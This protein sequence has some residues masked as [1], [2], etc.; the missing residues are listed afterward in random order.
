MTFAPHAPIDSHPMF[1]SEDI[2]STR[3]LKMPKHI[4]IIMDGN[5]RW[6]MQKGLPFIMGHRE[7]AEVLT[8]I[9]RAA[10]SFGIQTITVYSFS[11]ENWFRSEQ[12]VQG[13]LELFQIYLIGQM[14]QMVRDGIRL[15]TIGDLTRFPESLQNTFAFV[16]KNTV[17]CRKINLVLALNYGARDE[18][19]R[20][21]VKI[22]EKNQQQRMPPEELTEELISRHLDTSRWGDPELMIRTG[23]ELRL[24]NFLLWQI[25]YAEIYVTEKLWPD[26]SSND[27]LEAL[28]SFQKRKRRWGR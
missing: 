8:N 4:A 20:A 11:T 13:V 12:E 7:G 17:D 27:L 2:K 19:R 26:F 23:G 15:E 22:L 21:V 28:V 24:S 14:E 10:Q 18:I 1:G 25:S 16:K 6:A 9:V 5:R 3:L